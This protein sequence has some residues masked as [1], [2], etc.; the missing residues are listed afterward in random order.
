MKE[1]EKVEINDKLLRAFE[2][3]QQPR[4]EYQLRN[5]VVYNHETPEQQYAHCVLE[6]QRKYIALRKAQIRLE[7]EKYKIEQLKEKGD[8]LSEFKW[9]EKE[10]DMEDIRLT[11]IGALREFEVLYRMWNEFDKQYTR[12]EIDEAQPEYWSKRIDRQSNH[13]LLASGRVSVGNLEVRRQIGKGNVPELDYIRQVEER[14]LEGSDGGIRILIAVA[15]KHKTNSLTCIDNM[16]I[17]AGVQYIPYNV[18]G[19]NIADAYNDIAMTFLHGKKNKDGSC[20]FGSADYLL[21]IEDDTFPPDD[22]L[23]KLINHARNGKDAI[24]GWYPK[25]QEHREGA[26]V[27]IM[28]DGKRGFLDADGEVHEVYILPMGC[29]LYS[30]EAFLKTT[31]P[32]FATTNILTQDSFFSQKLRD[33]GFKLYCD[34]SI[35]CKHLDRETSKVYE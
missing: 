18:Y 9:R 6:L 34:T 25:R 20:K 7:K 15:T 23:I 33:A 12:K 31:F 19:R 14:L 30:K 21:T 3:I 28:S 29:A 17:P 26:P 13:D 35:R 32:Y 22:A 16:I 11:V 5:M 4:T 24:G 10:I 2:E 1:L 8:K 27:A